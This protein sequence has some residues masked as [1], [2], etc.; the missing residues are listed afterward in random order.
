MFWIW[1]HFRIV[2]LSMT[3]LPS[4]P[5][6]LLYYSNLMVFIFISN[7]PANNFEGCALVMI[8]SI[9]TIRPF[10]TPDKPL[11]KNAARKKSR[12]FLFSISKYWLWIVKQNELSY[13]REIWYVLFYICAWEGEMWVTHEGKRGAGWFCHL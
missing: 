4:F 11:T 7:F 12:L 9:F 1:I 10:E 3:T 8:E 2:F 13:V 6:L 5:N